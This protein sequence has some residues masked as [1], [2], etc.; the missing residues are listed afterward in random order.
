MA[1]CLSVLTSLEELHFHFESPQ[2]SPDQESRRRRPPPPTRS[3]LP[4]LTMFS[5]KGVHEYLEDFVS[6]I[7]A[8]RLYWLLIELFDYIDSDTP[9]LE[10]FISRTPRFGGYN[11][12]CLI[13]DL[14]R[15]LVRLQSHPDHSDHHGMVQVKISCKLPVL[16]LSSLAQVCNSPLHHLLTMDNLYFV[17]NRYLSRVWTDDDID[18]TDWLYILYPFTAVKNLYLSEAFWPHIAPALQELA[19]ERTA[20]VLPALEN[21]FLEGFQPSEPVQEGITEFISARQLTDHPVAISVWDGS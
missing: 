17:A 15:A 14:D 13:F 8:P 19:E 18:I 3:V 21:V 11:E 20:E 12:A 7:D 9:E 2:P 5:F 4:T 10:Q 16:Q 1:A 6:R